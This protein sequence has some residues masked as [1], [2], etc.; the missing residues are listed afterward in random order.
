MRGQPAIDGV[1][2]RHLTTLRCARMGRNGSPS[3][4]RSKI[5]RIV[6]RCFRGSDKSA[7][8]I[9]SMNAECASS[10]GRPRD[11]A[12]RYPG[13]AACPTIFAT[14]SRSIPNRHAASRDPAAPPCRPSN[15]APRHKSFRPRT[16]HCDP[17]TCHCRHL[18]PPQAGWSERFRGRL[19]GRH[20]HIVAF[21]DERLTGALLDRMTCHVHML[22]WNGE[23]YR[24]SRSRARG[25]A[26]RR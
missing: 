10:C 17:E 26:S 5:R 6:C 11:R 13:G 19:R 15:T 25:A 20:S 22:G 14:V 24:L 1:D 18:T 3:R 16:N 9:S 7:F 12:C 8:R 2:G 4:R 21:G 23:S